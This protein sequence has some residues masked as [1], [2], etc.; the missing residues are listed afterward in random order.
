MLVMHRAPRKQGWA[1][2][3]LPGLLFRQPQE[4]IQRDGE[5][6]R[7]TLH[8]GRAGQSF[9]DQPLA[10]RGGAD[11]EVVGDVGAAPGNRDGVA[12]AVENEIEAPSEYRRQRSIVVCPCGVFSRKVSGVSWVSWVSRASR[13]L[14]TLVGLD[15]FA[16]TWRTRGNNQ[17]STSQ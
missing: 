6:L 2:P 13:Q 8:H 5:M 9:A 10:H 14:G 4:K 1:E 7:Q 12:G 16:F 17:D 15:G 11:V 3:I